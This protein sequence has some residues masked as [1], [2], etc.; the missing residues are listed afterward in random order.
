MAGEGVPVPAEATPFLLGLEQPAHGVWGD[1][2]IGSEGFIYLPQPFPDL[3][4]AARVVEFLTALTGRRYPYPTL[5]L[6]ALDG[7]PA[8]LDGPLGVVPMGPGGLVRGV[9]AQWFGGLVNAADWSEVWLHGGLAELAAQRWIELEQGDEAGQL[10]RALGIEQALAAQERQP[11]ALVHGTC[12]EPGDLLDQG[13]LAGVGAT[14]L[15]LLRHLLGD[16]PFFAGLRRFVAEGA[17]RP[18]RTAELLVAL[19]GERAD[20]LR[21][22]FEQPGSPSL[23]ISWT[24]DAGRERILLTVNQVHEVIG[25]VPPVFEFPLDLELGLGAEAERRRVQLSARRELFELPVSA[26][27]RW[28]LG[29]PEAWLPV[30]ISS[31]KDLAEWRA[32]AWEAGVVGRRRAVRALGAGTRAAE[33]EERGMGL[34]LLTGRLTGDASPAVRAE[35]ARSLGVVGGDRAREALAAAATEDA[36]SGVRAAALHSL[37]AVGVDAELANLGR[38]LYREG[39]RDERPAAALLVASAD[40]EG[41]STWLEGLR[42]SPP[43]ARW[44]RDASLLPALTQVDPDAAA[45]EAD[46]LAFD[47]VVAREDRVAATRTLGRLLSARPEL[48]GRLGELLKVGPPE[49]QDAAVDAL[50]SSTSEGA[51]RL[52]LAFYPLTTTAYQRR[53]IEEAV[54]D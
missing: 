20:E 7:R 18:A 39:G 9:A 36:E 14:R 44:E 51:R 30:A 32:I 27:P 42:R 23:E 3:E 37:C 34:D 13:L 41:A 46:G 26:E 24:Y 54:G 35:A 19:A 6:G 49:V 15:Q 22:W 11:R 2:G 52:L 50:A 12:R 21:P 53:R 10:A 29:D 40:P 28:V 16:D 17:G 25:G 31:R 5:A 43:P 45:E 8:G 38:A 48:L 47:D 1:S 33:G 4:H